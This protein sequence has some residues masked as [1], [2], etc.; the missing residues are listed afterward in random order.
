[1]KPL[2]EFFDLL[3]HGEVYGW[4]YYA[5]PEKYGIVGCKGPSVCD[6]DHL[7]IPARQIFLSVFLEGGITVSLICDIVSYSTTRV[8][9]HLLGNGTTH[10]SDIQSAFDQIKTISTTHGQQN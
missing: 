10:H 3:P 9:V 4:L 5:E 6:F 2:V 1:M 8:R 7:G